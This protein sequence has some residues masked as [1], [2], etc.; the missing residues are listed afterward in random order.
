VFTDVLESDFTTLVNIT[1][2][3]DWVVQNW[4]VNRE[5][6]KGPYG[7][8][9]EPANVIS[10][11]AVNGSSVGINGKEAGLELW[12]RSRT[13]EEY[14]S[15]SEVDSARADMLYGSFRAGIKTNPINGTCAAFF[16]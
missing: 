1:K 7:R 15:V 3:T 16:W 13:Q 6:S 8:K 12:V 14:V 10:N 5:S 9:T 4:E 2:D 11:P